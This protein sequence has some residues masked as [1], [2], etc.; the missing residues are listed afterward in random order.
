M[1]PRGSDADAAGA[2][3]QARTGVAPNAEQMIKANQQ[4]WPAELKA[5]SKRAVDQAATDEID[6][7]AAQ[8]LLEGEGTVVSWAVRGPFV[9]LVYEDDRGRLHKTV[10]AREGQE[11]QVQRATRSAAQPAEKPARPRRRSRRTPP[12]SE[13]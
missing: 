4:R 11:S 9:V 3:L 6:Q 12:P 7:S 13:E 5:A 8:A 1:S 10:V 2:E